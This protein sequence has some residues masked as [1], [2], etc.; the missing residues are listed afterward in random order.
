MTKKEFTEKLESIQK[1]YKSSQDNVTE[2]NMVI[3]E[4]LMLVVDISN[5]GIEGKL[6][7]VKDN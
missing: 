3:M 7:V 5:E 6:M 2:L 4:C 1:R